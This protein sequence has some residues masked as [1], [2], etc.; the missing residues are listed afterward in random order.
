MTALAGKGSDGTARPCFVCFKLLGRFVMTIARHLKRVGLALPV[1]GSFGL[2]QSA[3]AIGT[4]SGMSISNRATVSY[5]VGQRRADADRKLA[6]GQQYARRE[7]WCGHDVRRRQ[8]NSARRREVGG[9]ANSH[10]PWCIERRRDVSRDQP[11]QYV[12]GLRAH[13]R[14]IRRAAPH[15]RSAAAAQTTRT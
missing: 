7:Q 13:C 10:Q 2:M 12:A 14:R 1:L 15:H 11:R 5:S 3:F 8:Q 4:D 9:T 6:D